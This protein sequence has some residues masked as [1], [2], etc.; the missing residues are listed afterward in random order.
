MRQIRKIT[1]KVN[2]RS[3]IWCVNYTKRFINNKILPI[4]ALLN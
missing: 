4:M 2:I 1:L 3:V